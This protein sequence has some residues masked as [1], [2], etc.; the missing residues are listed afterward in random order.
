MILVATAYLLGL[1]PEHGQFLV[2]G[3]TYVT[4]GV[5]KNID[6]HAAG[7]TLQSI[8]ASGEEDV[9]RV[10]AGA[11]Q[12]ARRKIILDQNVLLAK[13]W[14]RDLLCGK[15]CSWCSLSLD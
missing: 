8:R 4:E 9:L 7:D 6:T 15:K 10:M 1:Q 12:I 5:E 3:T 11:W 2:K 13:Q 14:G